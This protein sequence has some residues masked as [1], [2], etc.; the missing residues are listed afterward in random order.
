[1][2]SDHGSGDSGSE[3]HGPERLNDRLKRDLREHAYERALVGALFLWVPETRSWPLTRPNTGP[4][5]T[6]A[7]QCHGLCPF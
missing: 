2:T 3:A 4:L 5:V 7:T 6:S 1:M